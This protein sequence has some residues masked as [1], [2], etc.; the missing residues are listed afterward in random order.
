VSL[1]IASKLGLD[2]SEYTSGMLQATSIAE[3]FPSTVTHFLANP[4]LGLVDVAK[5]AADAIGAVASAWLGAIKEVGKAADDAGEM[6][7]KL[8]ISVDF[9]VGWG[10][11]F[12]DAGSSME[13][14]SDAVRFLNKNMAEAADGN[15]A[16]VESFRKLGLG[17][18]FIKANLGNTEAAF[19]QVVDA[20]A[21]LPTAA[22]RTKA[23][24][25]LM[26]RGGAD[27]GAALVQGSAGLDEFAETIHRL[28]GGS[29]VDLAVMGDK[30]GTLETLVEAAMF[31]I[32]RA[33]AEPVLKA[34]SDHSGEATH[35]LEGVSETLRGVVGYAAQTATD[36]FGSLSNEMLKNKDVAEGWKQSID[37]AITGV[38]LLVTQ[39]GQLV[40]AF[41]WLN[42]IRI[43]PD[44]GL[45]PTHDTSSMSL[46]TGFGSSGGS[47]GPGGG[48]VFDAGAGRGFQS[49]GGSFSQGPM[50]SGGGS[51]IVV[52]VNLPEGTSVAE[53][54]RQTA[55]A[56][57]A[58]LQMQ[59]VQSRARGG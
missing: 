30:F 5:G 57:Y 20:I 45:W 25:D 23:A 47:F 2:L 8:G 16:V 12:A 33:A 49:S 48:A 7:A 44:L 3:L 1:N 41:N 35:A 17:A 31:G 56:T 9:F 40:Q 39:I 11:A 28:R 52:N 32:K 50:P 26:G 15:A 38:E 29:E 18:D 43:T 58:A 24:M 13:G 37:D 22:E 21:A 46:G 4:L 55:A 59:H 53:I 6:A 51:Q 42:Q 10:T 14:F 36:R 27:L 19:R 54:Q 34:L